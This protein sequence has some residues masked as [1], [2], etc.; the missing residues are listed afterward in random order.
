MGT[1]VSNHCLIK[2][3]FM[4]FTCYL[5]IYYIVVY[6]PSININF[7]FVSLYITHFDYSIFRCFIFYR[8][9]V[10]EPKVHSVQ[11]ALPTYANTY[12][13]KKL[14]I[15]VPNYASVH[16]VNHPKAENHRLYPHHP[17]L[18][19]HQHPTKHPNHLLRT[20]NDSLHMPQKLN[21]L[22]T[23]TLPQLP[24]S[25]VAPSRRIP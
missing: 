1:R 17:K 2:I 21:L 24:S 3:C 5:L 9:Y 20:T 19:N 7:L 22:T 8:K 11:S 18:A 23:A 6:N 4:K 15:T 10:A 13:S 12:S 25:S 16:H 14:P